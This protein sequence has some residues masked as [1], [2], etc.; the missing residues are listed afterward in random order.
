MNL[1]KVCSWNLPWGACNPANDVDYAGYKKS[2]CDDEQT[3]T[4]KSD[5]CVNKC[6]EVSKIVELVFKI[7]PS[8]ALK[9][10]GRFA[11]DGSKFNLESAARFS[12]ADGPGPAV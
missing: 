5:A 3:G 4:E 11:G 2:E 9:T 6:S 10:S 7:A 8:G 12:A 1:E